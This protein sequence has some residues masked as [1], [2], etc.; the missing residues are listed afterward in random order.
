MPRI[1]VVKAAAPFAIVIRWSTVS[2]GKE[3]L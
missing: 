1:A 3:L 2:V